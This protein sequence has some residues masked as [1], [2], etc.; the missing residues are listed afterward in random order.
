MTADAI[1]RVHALLEA[2]GLAHAIREFPA[3]TATAAD[4]AAALGCEVAAIAKS[5]VFRAGSRPVLAIASGANRISKAKLATLLGEKLAPAGPDFVLEATG[6]VAGGVSPIGHTSET[7]IF[8]DEDLTAL[9]IVWAAA[10][11]PRHVFPV[12]PADLVRLTG[13]ALADIRQD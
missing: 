8:I 12:S 4:A 3:G 5:I 2:A 11:S 9:D 1:A 7:R 13:G 6:F 10:G